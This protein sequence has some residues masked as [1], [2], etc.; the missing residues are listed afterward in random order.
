MTQ[1]VL[2]MAI[3]PAVLGSILLFAMVTGYV[4]ERARERLKRA[5]T[6]TLYPFLV[7]LFSW[8][9]WDAAQQPYWLGFSLNLFAAIVFA[10]QFILWLRSDSIVSRARKEKA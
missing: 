9:A 7:L 10:V 2:F 4:S 8:L 6:A 3:V 5:L 1:A